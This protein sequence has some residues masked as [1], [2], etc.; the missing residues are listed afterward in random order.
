[1]QG[2]RGNLL[3]FL[4]N[5]SKILKLLMTLNNFLPQLPTDYPNLNFRNPTEVE[6][7][8]FILKWFCSTESSGK[9]PVKLEIMHHLIP[10]NSKVIRLSGFEA[11]K[12]LFDYYPPVLEHKWQFQKPYRYWLAESNPQ[13]LQMVKEAQAELKN[14]DEVSLDFCVLANSNGKYGVLADGNHRFTKL[15]YLKSQGVD[16]KL[17]IKKINLD[18]ILLEDPVLIVPFDFPVVRIVPP[19]E[20]SIHKSN[21]FL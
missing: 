21:L 17:K 20:A 5:N 3:K 18:V 14:L 12:K 10:V 16:I 1:M 19:V 13:Y 2:L 9:R 11:W 15:Y 6:L 7:I 4:V 8:E